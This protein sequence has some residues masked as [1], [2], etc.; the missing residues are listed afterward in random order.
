M[1][2]TVTLKEI[3][4]PKI[5]GYKYTGEFR[6]PRKGEYFSSANKAEPMTHEDASGKDTPRFILIQ[7]VETVWRNERGRLYYYFGRD[8]GSLC[9]LSD[10]DECT[11]IDDNRHKQHNYFRTHA[12]A[13]FA[14]TG[15]LETLKKYN[16]VK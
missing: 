14:L 12:D 5:Q 8:Q 9:V 10:I 2:Q 15:I 3:T 1:N 6:N 13:K 4:L 16:P 7:E 11:F